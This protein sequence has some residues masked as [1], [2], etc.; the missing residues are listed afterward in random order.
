[1]FLIKFIESHIEK[2][3]NKVNIPSTS[4]KSRAENA[5]KTLPANSKVKKN[6]SLVIAHE[7]SGA[8]NNSSDG[9]NNLNNEVSPPHVNSNNVK[10]TPQITLPRVMKKAQP[11]IT[12]MF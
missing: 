12:G 11:A 6:L 4:L 3:Y 9:Q 7:E 2:R 10:D 8:S 5:K 1:M